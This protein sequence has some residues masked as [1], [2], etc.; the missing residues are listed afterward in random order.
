ML[1]VLN[2]FTQYVGAALSFSGTGTLV[3]TIIGAL[4]GPIGAISGAA[5]GLLIGTLVQGSVHIYEKTRERQAKRHAERVGQ[6]K[7]VIKESRVRT[8]FNGGLSGAAIGAFVAGTTL[9][10][11]S[12]FV[13]PIPVVGTVIGTLAGTVVGGAIGATVGVIA[14]QL[15]RNQDAKAE[16]AAAMQEAYCP[17]STTRSLPIYPE[18]YS[19][20]MAP[21]AFQ[22]Y[23]PS[24]YTSVPLQP[25]HSATTPMAYQPYMPY[26]PPAPVSMQQPTA[27][28]IASN[29]RSWVKVRSAFWPKKPAHQAHGA[30]PM[31]PQQPG[32]FMSAPTPV[33]AQPQPSIVI[34]L[35][36]ERSFFGF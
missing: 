9:G 16:G 22:P 6:E 27:S 29:D 23:V 11:I 17:A 14:N 3:G 25:Y 13:I 8:T 7:F 21:V 36:P 30:Y 1:K 26:Y 32:F 31:M 33:M 18:G 15:Q 19:S 5:I 2:R 28:H 35:P 4:G 12:S 24:A 34:Q 20:V 10:A